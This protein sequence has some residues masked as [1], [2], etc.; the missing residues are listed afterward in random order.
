M[1][2][3]NG[4]DLCSFELLKKSSID[5]NTGQVCRQEFIIESTYFKNAS[6]SAISPIIILQYNIA[7]TTINSKS[8]YYY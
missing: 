8:W 2:A 1:F 5:Q 3:G 7:D 6:V 4:F